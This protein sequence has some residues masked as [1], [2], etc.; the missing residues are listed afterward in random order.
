MKALTLSLAIL[1]L[2]GSAA[3]GFFYIQ[4][5]NTKTVLQNELS[6]E[7]VKST[8]LKSNLDKTSAERDELQTK[9]SS[10]DA[11]LGD[12]KSKLTASEAQSFQLNRDLTQIKGVAAK[13]EAETQKLNA[14]VSELRRDLVQARI[15][16]Q[17]G[18]PEEIE[19]YK[20][21]IASLQSKL[22]VFQPEGVTVNPSDATGTP[23][24]PARPTSGTSHVAVVGPKNSFVVLDIGSSSGIA[25]GQKFLVAR[26]GQVLAEAIVSEVKD[27]YA[28][29][30]ITPSS[31]KG[32]LSVGD[33][34]SY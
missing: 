27:T 14:E 8:G 34:A 23:G 13:S 16:A 17:T 33:I 10:T 20:Q 31:I 32:A 3:S 12:T 28:I 25:P 21:T 1:A 24:Q 11:E 4:I 30:Q 2:L 7:Q 19:K 29:A 18:S 15:E 5:G 26:A 6:T 9:L 22:A